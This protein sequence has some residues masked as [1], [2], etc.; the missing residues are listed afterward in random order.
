MDGYTYFRVKLANEIDLSISAV[1][2]QMGRAR[3][4]MCVSGGFDPAL[5]RNCVATIKECAE[6]IATLENLK[7]Q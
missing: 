1:L 6:C 2:T 7:K 5:T 3:E 4:N